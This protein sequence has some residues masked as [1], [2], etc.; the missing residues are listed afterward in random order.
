MASISQP[1]QLF[2]QTCYDL[3]SWDSHLKGESQEADIGA[4]YL[5]RIGILPRPALPCNARASN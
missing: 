1:I 5:V 3:E 2:L 4:T